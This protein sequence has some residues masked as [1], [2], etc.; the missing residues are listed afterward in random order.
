MNTTKNEALMELE[1]TDKA[2]APAK[3]RSD[4]IKNLHTQSSPT[5]QLVAEVKSALAIQSDEVAELTAR[6]LN[7][8]HPGKL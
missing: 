7:L 6:V 3:I 2:G 8:A 4:F 5:P 1:K